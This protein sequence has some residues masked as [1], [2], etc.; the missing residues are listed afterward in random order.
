[1]PPLT[2]VKIPNNH[3]IAARLR[4]LAE[5]CLYLDHGPDNLNRLET[6]LN[7][8]M[9]LHPEA[10]ETYLLMARAYE[11]LG[12]RLGVKKA[13]LDKRIVEILSLA[14]EQDPDNSQ[15]KIMLASLFLEKGDTRLAVEY[16]RDILKLKGGDSFILEQAGDCYFS[17]GDKNAAYEAFTRALLMQPR[18]HDLHVKRGITLCTKGEYLDACGE[19]VKALILLPNH[20]EAVRLKKMSITLAARQVNKSQKDLERE[21]TDLLAPEFKEALFKSDFEAD[22]LT[23]FATEGSL[24]LW[25]SQTHLRDIWALSAHIP[26]LRVISLIRGAKEINDLMV[27]IATCLRSIYPEAVFTSRPRAD[28]FIVFSISDPAPALPKL[29]ERFLEF[30]QLCV[31]QIG[32]G[33]GTTVLAALGMAIKES[34]KERCE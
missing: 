6:Y 13:D 5:N 14:L 31:P 19:A 18:S 34:L 16:L 20:R 32:L 2:E 15:A 21:F 25:A 24:Q 8:S 4:S 10:V 28:K 26:D 11:L 30:G 23:G 1:M 9:Q 22:P 27:K 3:I 29:K 33:R 17:L 7:D 12:E